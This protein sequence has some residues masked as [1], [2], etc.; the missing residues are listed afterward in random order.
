MSD[1]ALKKAE[2]VI[3]ALYDEGRLSNRDAEDLETAI[4]QA[5][6]QARA[7][8]MSEGL[9][10]AARLCERKGH[11]VMGYAIRQSGEESAK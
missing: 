10:Q 7:E 1:W 2:N 3:Q 8:G 5:L 9:D 4:A 6:R 11:T